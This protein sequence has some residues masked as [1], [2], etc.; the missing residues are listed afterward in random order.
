[1]SPD[2]ILF[3]LGL[4]SHQLSD[5]SR[6]FSFASPASLKVAYGELNSLPPARLQSLNAL[7]RHLGYPPDVADILSG[8]TAAD[9]AELI[10]FYGEE[11]YAQRVAQ[12]LKA[13]LPIPDGRRLAQ[14]VADALPSGYEHG[15]IH[16][17]TRTFQALRLAV[18]RELEVL[19]IA[20]PQALELLKPGG[21]VAVISFHSLEDRI[22]KQ[23]FRAHKAELE[24]LTKKPVRAGESEVKKNPRSRSAKLRAAKKL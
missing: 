3:D 22:V 7:E 23:F 17:A 20:L 21:V 12:A 6:A 11:R 14:T 19:E 10:R 4:G 18:N 9:L 16:P 8:L 2:H 24:I 1:M 5:A 15:R 13:S